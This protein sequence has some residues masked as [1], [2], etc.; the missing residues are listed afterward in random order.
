MPGYRARWL[1]LVACL[2][3]TLA[4][5]ETEK[6]HRSTAPVAL[7]GNDRDSA[8]GFILLAAK[9]DPETCRELGAAVA[10]AARFGVSG[11]IITP[12]GLPDPAC[13]SAWKHQELA[14]TAFLKRAGAK[15]TDG[16]AF[17]I[18]IVDGKG[19][20]RYHKIAPA[21]VDGARE[22][23]R[24]LVLWEQGRGAF[25]GHCGHCHGDDG[26]GSFHEGVRPLTAITTRMSDA[27]IL[28]AGERF[29]AVS[30]S[31]W[32][33]GEVNALILYLRGM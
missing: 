26:L 11:R 25:S 24:E 14:D 5:A 4:A 29:G 30:I 21:T 20:I 32:S 7:R 33:A 10:L 31:T 17:A 23:G 19:I 6:L 22:T 16:A 18:L 27:R 12:A 9:P 2:M 15:T 13:G 3:C 1:T 28:D 8:Q